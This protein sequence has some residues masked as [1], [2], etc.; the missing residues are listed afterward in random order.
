MFWMHGY[1]LEGRQAMRS[2]NPLKLNPIQPHTR[3]TAYTALCGMA[4]ALSAGPLLATSD[5]NCPQKTFGVRDI[6]TGID[7]Q[8]RHI[9]FEPNLGGNVLKKDY[10]QN[11]VFA[12]FKFHE[13]FGL[14][15]GYQWTEPKDKWSRVGAGAQVYGSSGAWP[16]FDSVNRLRMSGPSLD[17]VGSYKIKS[18]G[19]PESVV[20][21]S[22]GISRLHT[23][24]K[25]VPTSAGF[26]YTTSEIMSSSG[27]IKGDQTALRIAPAI[28]IFLSEHVGLRA[29]FI[30]ENLFKKNLVT[31]ISGASDIK[32]CSAKAKGASHSYGL[33][34]FWRY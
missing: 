11:N 2:M 8:F 3:S 13:H 12:G 14:E 19:F 17:L 27:R 6:Y 29:R 32:L 31:Y 26:F 4:L 18:H 16:S 1:S 21:L 10:R 20:S 33:G 5:L 34:V 28:D 9:A 25:Y 30:Y 7:Q 23:H 15:L 24:I 22:M